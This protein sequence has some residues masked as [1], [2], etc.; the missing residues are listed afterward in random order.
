MKK[1]LTTVILVFLSM[2]LIVG[3]GTAKSGTSSNQQAGQETP[4]AAVKAAAEPEQDVTLK[5]TVFGNE[6]YKQ[7]AEEIGRDFTALHPHIKID[8]TLIP[9]NEY[10]QKLSIMLAS[11]NAPDL[12]WMYYRVIKQYVDAG[13]LMDI[14]EELVNDPSYDFEDHNKNA[15]K[16]TE[17]EK[18]GKIYGAP[19]QNSPRVLFFNK[20]LFKEKG[21]KTPLELY[22]EGNWTYDEMVKAAKAISDPSKGIYGLNLVTQFGWSSWVDNFMD[23]IWAYGATL[24]SDDG[25][26]FTLNS[27]EGEKALQFWMDL[28]FKEQ[29]HPKPGDQTAFESGKI[30]MARNNFSYTATVRKNAPNLDWDIAPMPTGPDKKAY[31]MDGFAGVS[32]MK[33]AKHPQEA[34]LFLKYLTGVEGMEKLSKMYNPNRISLVKSG[35]LT[36]DV[37]APTQEGVQAALIDRLEKGTKAGPLPS[38]WQQIDVKMQQ[39]LDLLYSKSMTP[40]EVLNKMEQEITPLLK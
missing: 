15:W 33:A 38:N 32:V 27:P 26:T 29:V 18:D 2:A 5:M 3:C 21:L 12:A 1:G 22:K 36:K 9:L 30:G 7:V 31:V 19:M 11:N 40:K 25:K 28:I 20:T 39:L 34:I 16:G 4:G 10:S 8:V 13:Q 17:L 6:T 23:T 35:I 14:T 24:L 37:K